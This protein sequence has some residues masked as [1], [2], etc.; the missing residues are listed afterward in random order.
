M[1]LSSVVIVLGEVLEAAILTSIFLSLSLRYETPRYWFAVS[2]LTGSCFAAFYAFS[3]DTVSQ[4]FD[5]FGQEVVNAAILFT[6]YLC[7]L[8]FNTLVFTSKQNRQLKFYLQLIMT[9]GVSL[10]ITREGSE[11][12][13]YLS[14]FFS[15]ETMAVPVLTGSILGA[16]I[17]VS[18][19]ILFY[20]AITSMN[21]KTS[22][23]V[24]YTLFLFV[25]AGMVSQAVRLLIQIDWLPSQEIVWDISSWVD[26]SSV[27][28]RLLFALVGYEATPTAIE[29]EFYLASVSGILITTMLAKYYKKAD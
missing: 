20:Y 24:G 15:S 11:I 5:G 9:V 10:A 23:Y 4:W 12:F 17:G 18:L 28:G 19:G 3:F 2:L 26:E 14:G 8:L 29:I 22:L 27:T 21:T 6:I 1:I 25:A 7:L 16:G 13:I